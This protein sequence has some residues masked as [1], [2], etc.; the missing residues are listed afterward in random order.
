MSL[1]FIRSIWTQWYPPAPTFG[2]KDVGD[3]TGKVFLITGANAGIG[4]ELAKSLYASGATIYMAGRDERRMLESIARIKEAAAAPTNPATLK[5]LY[6]DLADLTSVKRAAGD[7][8]KWESKL[9]ILWNN[10]GLG[11]APVGTTT[12]Q[13]IEGHIGTNCVA[14]LLFTQLVLPQL[15]K[16]ATDVSHGT[17]RVI[18]S[19]SAMVDTHS[20]TGGIDFNDIE[21]GKTTNTI[22]D[23]A[24]SKVGN[25]F[26]SIEAAKAWGPYGISSVV[27]NPGNLDTGAYRYQ[28]AFLIFVLRLFTLYKA[29]YGAYTLLYS[30][31]SEEVQNG[32]FI[33]PWGR[34]AKSERK[35]IHEEIEKG[36]SERFW[37]WCE[38]T[39]KPY[40]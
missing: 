15:R 25:W 11:G 35:D 38:E 32:D 29:E 10:A 5:F 40:A 37:K 1:G 7:F 6:L 20:K 12:A 14:P 22:T 33:W 4:Y 34:K 21:A 19:G 27:Q 26:L 2:A 8:A 16:A 30:G 13:N 17:V 23:Y 24:A 36:A 3:Q 31:L 9:D 28:S 18:W 39:A